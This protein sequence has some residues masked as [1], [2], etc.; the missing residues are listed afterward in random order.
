MKSLPETASIEFGETCAE[1]QLP[2]D[3]SAIGVEVDARE[4]ARAERQAPGLVLGERKARAVA[5]EHPEVGEQ[6]MAQVDGLG[7]LQVGVARQRP[8]EVLLRTREHAR[9]SAPRSPP[10]PAR[11]ARA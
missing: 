8:V 7:A 4:R 11:R 9:P 1:T 10:A 6:V 5:R 3:L 2:G